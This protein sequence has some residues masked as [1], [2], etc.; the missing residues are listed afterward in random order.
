MSSAS[1]LATK[2]TVSPFSAMPRPAPW[3]PRRARTSGRTC[4]MTSSIVAGGLRYDGNRGSGYFGLSELADGASARDAL[5]WLSDLRQAAMST[6]MAAQVTARMR[7]A[8]HFQRPTPNSQSTRFERAERKYHQHLRSPG[9]SPKSF[10][11]LA[12]GVG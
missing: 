4:G 3:R 5:P 1:T 11:Y 6:A 8:V 7:L 12:L 2:S 10:E 9:V